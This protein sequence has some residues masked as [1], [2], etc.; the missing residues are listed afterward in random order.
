[1]ADYILNIQIQNLLESA[2][3][4]NAKKIWWAW[5]RNKIFIIV[6]QIKFDIKMY[7]G[8]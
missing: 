2:K 7:Q 6:T 3:A 4:E 5:I 8:F 1:M